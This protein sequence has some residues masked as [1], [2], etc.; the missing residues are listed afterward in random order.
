MAYLTRPTRGRIALWSVLAFLWFLFLPQEAAMDGFRHVS[1]IGAIFWAVVFAS[2]I[3]MGTATW[4]H[5]N[6]TGRT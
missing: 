2:L 4:R 1:V 5:R 3:M 6:K